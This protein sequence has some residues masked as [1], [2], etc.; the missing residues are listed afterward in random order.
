[1]LGASLATFPVTSMHS[2]RYQAAALLGLDL[3]DNPL[4]AGVKVCSIAT[5]EHLV[6]TTELMETWCNNFAFPE[7]AEKAA[8][9]LQGYFSGCGLILDD[10]LWDARYDMSKCTWLW[11]KHVFSKL[12]FRSR[13]TGIGLHIRWGDM[14]Y[15]S[16]GDPITPQRSTPIP[17]G[18]HLLQKMRECGIIGCFSKWL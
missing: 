2:T 18:A 10:R 1:M 8:V 15:D 5:S 3:L 7:E 13:G 16:P 17:V 6:S 11:V 12:G 4:D 14:S 9:E